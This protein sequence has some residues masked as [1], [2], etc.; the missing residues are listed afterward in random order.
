[1]SSECGTHTVIFVVEPR[2]APTDLDSVAQ[3]AVSELPEGVT[4]T[5][6]AQVEA[7][8]GLG[9]PGQVILFTKS[10]TVPGDGVGAA[11][12]TVQSDNTVGFAI[13]A[14]MQ[15]VYWLYTNDTYDTACGAA[16]FPGD[17]P[18]PARQLLL[19]TEFRWKVAAIGDISSSGAP[20][21]T[22]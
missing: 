17:Q 15:I 22:D 9:A 6:P 18:L 10:A 4:V 2:S 13:S 3:V 20:G 7:F 19:D 16:Y 11:P 21:A 14:D 5:G 8:P 12:R 1:M